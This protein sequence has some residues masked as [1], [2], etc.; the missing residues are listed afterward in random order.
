MGFS[1]L[2]TLLTSFGMGLVWSEAAFRLVCCTMSRTDFS[3]SRFP[4]ERTA[5][6]NRFYCSLTFVAIS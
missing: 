4:K 6:L 1:F 3:L 2:N 5:R